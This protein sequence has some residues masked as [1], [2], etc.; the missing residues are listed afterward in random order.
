MMFKVFRSCQVQVQIQVFFPNK[1]K[2][3]PPEKEKTKIKNLLVPL[4]ISC[5]LLKYGTLWCPSFAVILPL[6]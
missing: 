4:K 2:K 6:P 1:T 5:W 3:S